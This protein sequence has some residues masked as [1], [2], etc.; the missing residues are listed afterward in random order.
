MKTDNQKRVAALL[1]GLMLC[2]GAQDGQALFETVKTALEESGYCW[3]EVD[4]CAMPD[5]G[6]RRFARG[7]Q[8]YFD[9]MED[10]SGAA[11]RLA[12]RVD[13][14]QDSAEFLRA[15]GEEDAEQAARALK[16]RYEESLAYHS[17]HMD[18]KRAHATAFSRGGARYYELEG[19]W[20]YATFLKNR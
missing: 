8:G 2:T 12:F 13:Q 19:S 9:L 5:A 6:K 10:E 7:P 20:L 15:L 17:A 18:K 1:F 14:G 4:I 3:E 11:Q 16:T